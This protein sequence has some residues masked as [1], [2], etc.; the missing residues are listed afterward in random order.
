MYNFA[1]DLTSN[2]IA[3]NYV[4]GYRGNKPMSVDRVLAGLIMF[5]KKQPKNLVRFRNCFMMHVQTTPIKK[6]ILVINGNDS[7]RTLIDCMMYALQ[8]G[9]NNKKL[10]LVVYVLASG[11]YEDAPNLFGDAASIEQ[12]EEQDILTIDVP[13][14]IKA[15]KQR[16]RRD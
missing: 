14:L 2:D 7:R 5:H 1:D 10:K 15:S 6:Y 3:E 4:S 9:M 8:L 13:A 11:T 12:G 16:D